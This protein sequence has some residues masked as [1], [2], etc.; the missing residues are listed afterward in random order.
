MDLKEWPIWHQKKVLKQIFGGLSLVY[1]IFWWTVWTLRSRP[2]FEPEWSSRQI[3]SQLF[4]LMD[5][6]QHRLSSVALI[7]FLCYLFKY[8]LADTQHALNQLHSQVNTLSYFNDWKRAD[9]EHTHTHTQTHAHPLVCTSFS[10]TS[11]FLP[12]MHLCFCL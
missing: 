9:D 1:T 8:A 5:F 7:T 11:S 2:V 6:L 10:L 4:L 3:D 12:M